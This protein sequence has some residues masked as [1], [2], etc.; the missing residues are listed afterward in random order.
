MLTPAM[1]RGMVSTTAAASS[2][3]TFHDRRQRRQIHTFA[4]VLA[5][6][7]EVPGRVTVARSGGRSSDGGDQEVTYTAGLDRCAPPWSVQGGR[8]RAP[9]QPARD[10]TSRD[11]G[12]E[13]SLILPTIPSGR[14][15]S[16]DQYA[17]FRSGTRRS[18]PR[19]RPSVTAYQFQPICCS[20]SYCGRLDPH[21]RLAG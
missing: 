10:P 20:H 8:Q 21:R 9:H 12:G 6:P 5:N 17:S 2:L 16:S 11:S 19:Y 1:R 3:W 4:V 18:L 13:W 14:V 15:P 7:S